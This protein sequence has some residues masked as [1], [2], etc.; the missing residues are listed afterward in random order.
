[1]KLQWSKSNPVATDRNA[2]AGKFFLLSYKMTNS[3]VNFSDFGKELLFDNVD[4]W[5]IKKKVANK[6][7]NTADQKLRN[8]DFSKLKKWDTSDV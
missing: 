6:W 3:M 2:N 5:F 7:F 8:F 1:M 4:F